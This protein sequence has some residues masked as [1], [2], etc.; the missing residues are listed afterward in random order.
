MT[1]VADPVKKA[2]QTLQVAPERFFAAEYVVNRWVVNAD[3]STNQ[4][5]VLKGEYWGHVAAS[6]KPWDHIY[7]RAEN[8]TWYSELLVLQVARAYAAVQPLNEWKWGQDAAAE[9]EQAAKA[10]APYRSKWGG[11]QYKWSVIRMSD[12]QRVAEGMTSERDALDWIRE[13][14]KAG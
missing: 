13:R 12:N 2:S 4:A 11:P 9:A 3:D 1:E 6:L 10:S 14:E 7:V 5:D 8:G